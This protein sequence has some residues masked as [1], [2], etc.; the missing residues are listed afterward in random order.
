MHLFTEGQ[1]GHL[2]LKNRVV[3]APMCMYSADEAGFV[4][5]FHLSH[6]T[7]RAYGGV[8][9]IIQEATAVEPRGRISD[10]DLGIWDDA[11]VI[12]LKKLVDDVHLA[13]SKI[14]VQLAHAGRKCTVKTEKIIAPENVAFNEKYATPV[15]MQDKDIED[16]IRAFKHGA[17][18]AR[19]SG[20]DGIELHGAHGY[21]IN[22][23]ISPL[24]NQRTDKYGGSLENRARFLLDIIAAVREEW[25]GPLWVRL[26]AD[27]YTEGGHHIHETL[28]LTKLLLGKVDAINVSSGGV[29]PIVPKAFPG[30]QLPLAQAIKAQGMTVIGGGL[31]TNE[32]QI[33]QALEQHQLDF[34]YLARELLL[35]PYFVLRVAKNH[36]PEHQLK[37]YERG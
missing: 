17:R 7:A 36:A 8:S 32:N 16:V 3:M 10:H 4:Q 35:N 34:V 11:H 22:Q 19:L 12:G 2:T 29:V 33:E 15:A 31:I 6:Y 5:P 1:I 21:L 20:Y 26:S 28:E 18:R 37:A 9:L 23:F 24:T 25:Q 30:Y 14:A 27:E 13:G